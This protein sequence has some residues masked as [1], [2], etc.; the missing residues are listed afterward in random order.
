MPGLATTD[1]ELLRLGS[2]VSGQRRSL[3]IPGQALGSGVRGRE[4]TASA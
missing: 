2:A 3:T 4:W 1:E